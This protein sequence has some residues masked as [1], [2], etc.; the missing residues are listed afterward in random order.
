MLVDKKIKGKLEQSLAHYH[1]LIY[2]TV[3][4]VP[5]RIAETQDHFRSIPTDNELQWYDAVQGTSWGTKWKSAWLKGSIDL[6]KICN[7]RDVFVCAKTGAVETLLFVDGIARGILGSYI[8]GERNVPDHCAQ[9]ICAN[10]IS[11]K[12]VNIALEI[13]AGHPCVGCGTHEDGSASLQDDTAYKHT[14]EGVRIALRRDDVKDFWLDLTALLGLSD[15][16]DQNSL[17]YG[18]IMAGTR[19][20]YNIIPQIPYEV[21]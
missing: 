21:P 2:E 5:M 8:P 7:G 19:D 20:V 17:R 10:G 12:S 18:K 16:L 4:E 3:A 1:T 15:C 13:Y 9:R 14:F 11:G 6:P